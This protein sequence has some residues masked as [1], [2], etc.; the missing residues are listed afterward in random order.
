MADIG[1]GSGAGLASPQ[2]T[3]GPDR[4]PGR[5]LYLAVLRFIVIGASSLGLKEAAQIIARLAAPALTDADH[6]R[7]SPCRHADPTKIYRS[8][9]H[10]R[11]R[12]F[13]WRCDHIPP[14]CLD[15]SRS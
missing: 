10:P 4:G 13:I 15:E 2:P 5:R 3:G 12:D 11:T 9:T 1:G 6:P 14:H 7:P 8:G